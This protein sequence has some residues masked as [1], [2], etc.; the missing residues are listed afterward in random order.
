MH[1]RLLA[2]PS[3]AL[4]AAMLVGACSATVSSPTP[5]APGGG[6]GTA[7]ATPAAPGG[8]GGTATATPAA[9]GGATPPGITLPSFSIPSFSIPSFAIPSFGTSQLCNGKPTFSITASAQP[10]LPGDSTLAGKFPTQIAGQAPDQVQTFFFLDEMCL[11]GGLGIDQ[12]QAAFQQAGVDIT[13]ASIGQATYMVGEES[14]DL[15]ALRT[16][17]GDASKMVQGFAQLAAALGQANQL[18]NVTQQTVGGKSVYVSTDASGSTSYIYPAGD[19]L[20]F[21][22]TSSADNAGTVLAALP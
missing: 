15:T 7:T 21:F 16:P 1:R 2:V 22:D 11:F 8:G 5:A 6:G 9:P 4:V 14:I 10:S 17:G 3:L 20:W 13:T 18:K 19:T 12:M